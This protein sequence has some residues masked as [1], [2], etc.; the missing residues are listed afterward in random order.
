[1]AGNFYGGQ[2]FGGGFFG[3]ITPPRGGAGGLI[4]FVA[5]RGIDWAEVEKKKL[6]IQLARKEAELKKLEKRIKTVEK[7]A[8]KSEKPQGILANLGEL[9][10]KKSAVINQIETIEVN[11]DA[12]LQFLTSLE[13]DD[14]DDDLF[15]LL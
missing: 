13:F 15:L 7:K 1:M 3:S 12:V 8:E 14:D 5:H 6:E 11:L 4:T 2:F 9:I 10:A